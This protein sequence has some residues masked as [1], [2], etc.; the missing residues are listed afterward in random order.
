MFTDFAN[1]V[2]S[3]VREAYAHFESGI[4]FEEAARLIVESAVPYSSISSKITTSSSSLISSKE[5]KNKTSKN[6]VSAET[7]NV[8]E[9]ATA[10]IQEVIESTYHPE[11][12]DAE[13]TATSAEAAAASQNSKRRGRPSS[14]STPSSA[15]ATM[16]ANGSGDV[17]PVSKGRSRSEGAPKRSQKTSSTKK[18]TEAGAVSEALKIE[19]AIEVAKGSNTIDIC[20]RLL[21]VGAK[22]GLVCGSSLS[23]PI[24]STVEK[25]RFAASCDECSK[26]KTKNPLIVE[27]SGGGSSSSTKT[28]KTKKPRLIRKP[29]EGEGESE[30]EGK[31]QQPTTKPVVKI[32]NHTEEE[33]EASE[34]LKVEEA[35]TSASSK[36]DIQDEE[37]EEEDRHRCDKTIPDVIV[38]A[39]PEDHDKVDADEEDV[40][41]TIDPADMG[42]SMIPRLGKTIFRTIPDP[43]Q[44]IIILVLNSDNTFTIVGK[45]ANCD[46]E[47]FVDIVHEA[48]MT[49]A[50]SCSSV[51]RNFMGTLVELSLEEEILDSLSEKG[52]NTYRKR[53]EGKLFRL[54]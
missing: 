27:A 53:N 46:E 2:A 44:E 15:G 43:S 21:R 34:I 30:D 13:D 4:G 18:T 50:A 5:K 19:D 11:H 31:E 20:L 1:I 38:G 47:T 37:A 49:A 51:T 35:E 7:S 23:V 41:E 16:L 22:K 26:F 32:Y 6:V 24:S 14:K 52:I 3:V 17:P 10:Q 29:V 25:E 39:Q 54:D 28:P 12:D 48:A 33:E 9:E 45:I 8:V 42:L 40:L 36:N